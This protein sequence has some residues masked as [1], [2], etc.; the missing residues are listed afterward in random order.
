MLPHSLVIAPEKMSQVVKRG[1]IGPAF[2]SGGRPGL[3]ESL[4]DAWCVLGSSWSWG[5]YPKDFFLF[6]RAV[7]NLPRAGPLVGWL[8]GRSV[9][10]SVG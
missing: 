8:V 3:L 5:W 6:P 9:D 4:P 1:P 2:R 10:R 7:L